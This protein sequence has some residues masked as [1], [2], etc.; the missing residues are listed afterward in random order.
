MNP[1]TLFPAS[2]V[3]LLIAAFFT[4]LGL[5]LSW[6]VL[7]FHLEELGWDRT[8]IG[9]AN[10]VPAL[11]IVFFGVP[12]SLLIPRLGYVRSLRLGG[13][14]AAVG[15][16]LV[17]WAPLLAAVF[18]GLAMFGLGQAL[19]MG[20]ATPLLARLVEAKQQVAVL[21]WKAALGTGAGF[22]GSLAGGYLSSALG[23]PGQA[24]YLVPL[25]FAL[26][27]LPLWGLGRETGGSVG[28]FRLHRP[29]LWV[30]LLAPQLLVSLGAGGVMPFLNLYLSG[31]FG[32]SYEAIGLVF[33]LSALAT[34]LAMLI[35]PALARRLGKVG[36]IVFMQGASL[37]FIL[38]LAYAPWLPL[39]TVA[40]FMRG[41]LMNAANP[42]FAALAMERLKEEE[43][44]TFMLAQ[45]AIWNIGWA[46]SSSLSG[47]LQAQL[48]TAAFDY[49][50][51][52]ML[53]VY[54]LATAFYLIF[55]RNR[56][57]GPNTPAPAP[58]Q[59]AAL[60]AKSV[61]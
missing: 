39:V 14:L 61:R 53:V 4:G 47:R 15:G 34:M 23:G 52:A 38:I 2:V 7:N 60:E 6:L 49:L 21:S 10:A 48:G 55:F 57:Q 33:A 44:A 59:P 24:I 1:L 37:P 29:T 42:V 13:A 11:V 32:L 40:L 27:L 3:R 8:L 18:F 30:K 25:V 12:V 5:S 19:I 41:A 58:A 31:K 46:V 51:A 17:A 50:F 22:L 16:G 56:R 26:S 36:A 20:A 9:Y 45:T 43:R 35:Q 28:R 54:G